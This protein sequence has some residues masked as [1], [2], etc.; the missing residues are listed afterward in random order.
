MPR[1]NLAKLLSI[2]AFTLGASGLSSATVTYAV[3]TCKPGVSNFNTISA[4]L[5]AT[6]PPNVVL[7]C[8]GTYHEQV[9]IT[10]P[11]TLQGVSFDGSAQAIIAP[12]PNGLVA[13]ATDDL[14]DSIAAQLYIWIDPTAVESQIQNIVIDGAGNGI[15]ASSPYVV[16]IF[17]QNT[18]ATINHVTTRNQNGNGHGVGIWLEGGLLLP[19]ITVENSSIHGFDLYG[20]WSQTNVAAGSQ[21]TATISG[22]DVN[23]S[24]SSNNPGPQQ[25]G[26]VI[27]SGTTNTISGNVVAGLPTGILSEGTATG[28]ISGNT[29]LDD[30]IGILLNADGVSATGNKIYDSCPAGAVAGSCRGIQ[31]NSA[32]PAVQDN[33]IINSPI[34]IEFNCVANPNVH[35]N[36]ITNS[37]TGL[38]QVP[39][40]TTSTNALYGVF[41]TRTSCA[42]GAAR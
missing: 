36:T 8:P 2:L 18:P 20:T 11:V 29:L 6:P 42:A 14:G 34:G 28:T 38:A 16:G 19:A 15:T 40:G 26:I 7:V 41:R 21:L 31:V 32:V 39:A 10:Y 9:Q 30:S 22:N 35:S 4:A 3:G 37:T 5:A 23:G 25:T 27:N 13:N 24:F 12:P 33:T 1:I 17:V